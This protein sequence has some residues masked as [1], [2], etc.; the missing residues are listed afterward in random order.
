[1]EASLEGARGQERI[2][3]LCNVGEVLYRRGDA[4]GALR[5]FSE[6]LAIAQ[7]TGAT[8]DLFL[9]YHGVGLALEAA[10]ELEAA[11]ANY[12][13]A[14]AC[15]ERSRG[16]LQ[17]DALRQSYL[18]GHTAVYDHAADALL[19]LGR[20][21]EAFAAAERKK[22]RVLVDA[23]ASGGMRVTKAMTGEERAEEA[24]RERDAA[25]IARELEAAVRT[26]E[27]RA[28]RARL[29]EAR[30]GL[31]EL[32]ERMYLSHP[33]LRTLRAR[34]PPATIEELDRA[35]FSG[36]PRACVLSYAVIGSEAVL[37]LLRRGPEPLLVRTVAEDVPAL[38][39]RAR[40]LWSGCA[41]AKGENRAAARALYALLVAPVEK[42][43]ADASHVVVVPDGILHGIP[44]HALE[45]GS[46]R[47]LI[48]R[49]PVSYAPSVTA[50]AR[51]A[52][53]A[54]RRRAEGAA[55][56]DPM[57]AIGAPRMPRGFV[58]LPNAGKEAAGI[59]GA[60]GATAVL[61]PEATES[62]AKRD[63]CRARRIHL[64]THGKLDEASPMYSFVVLGADEENDGYLHAREIADLDL[65]AELAVLSA[66]ET[67][68]GRQ[69]EG[70][71]LVGLA[72]ALLVA[73]VPSTVVSQWQVADEATGLLMTAFYEN[74]GKGGTKAE[75]LR[76]AQIRLLR[77]GTHGHP[78]Y[79]APFVVVGDWR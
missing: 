42:E 9:C 60:F 51:M 28:L 46:G 6:A 66:C 18:A 64:A 50:L 17:A 5:S 21:A 40:E 8:G 39:A 52:E 11:L 3:P 70:E 65:R 27:R 77:D 14:E 71:G 73:G 59:A 13:L 35:L 48:E 63:L 58:N 4:S 20:K 1:Y 37:F 34:F 22:A 49:W 69:V 79:W 78:Y 45:D 2:V 26:D 23:L 47:R 15:I 76:Q 56:L 38:R 19:A 29:A 25:A 33:D 16:T 10:G 30:G 31:E 41:V 68:R 24:R 12:G 67:A 57:L 44:F 75:A 43:I 53:V 55:D 72:W 74:L 36:D 61:G 32:R 7:A 54:D 62:R